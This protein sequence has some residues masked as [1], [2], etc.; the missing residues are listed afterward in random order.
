M[1]IGTADG[2]DVGRLA[3]ACGRLPLGTEQATSAAR[4][5]ERQEKSLGKERWPP[6]WRPRVHH[7]G[8]PAPNQHLMPVTAV[9]AIPRRPLTFSP[10]RRTPRPAN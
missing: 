7:D 2:G 4:W 10:I 9:P 5:R 1:K 8:H 3:S 6:T